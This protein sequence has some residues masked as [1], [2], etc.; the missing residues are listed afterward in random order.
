PGGATILVI[1]D[2]DVA[3]AG[4][5]TLLQPTGYRVATAANGTAGLALLDGGMRPALILLDMIVPGVDGWQFLARRQKDTW[6]AA[7]PVVIMTGLGVASEEWATSL[8]ANDLLRKPIESVS[9]LSVV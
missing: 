9:L 2:D 3:R 5:T 4:L 8:G 6:L 1:E 7:I